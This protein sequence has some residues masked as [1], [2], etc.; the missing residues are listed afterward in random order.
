MCG[1]KMT[2]N[3]LKN[4]TQSGRFRSNLVHVLFSSTCDSTCPLEIHVGPIWRQIAKL[5]RKKQ[6][7][8]R[9]IIK[10]G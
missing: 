7:S 4:Q 10:C 9:T 5:A 2:S 3:Y 6:H 1:L 8:G